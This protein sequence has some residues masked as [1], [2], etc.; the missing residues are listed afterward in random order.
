MRLH[1][2]NDLQR[3]CTQKKGYNFFLFD[4]LFLKAPITFNML[5]QTVLFLYKCFISSTMSSGCRKARAS[6]WVTLSCLTLRVLLSSYPNSVIL[7]QVLKEK[8]PGSFPLRQIRVAREPFASRTATRYRRLSF[9]AL[10]HSYKMINDHVR[11]PPPFYIIFDS[12]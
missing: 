9:L 5:L 8:R 7:P 3:K 11:L 1:P 2:P 10:R 12:Y 4:R 6:W